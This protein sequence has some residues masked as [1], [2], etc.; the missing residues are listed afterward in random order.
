MKSL[1]SRIG[2][3]L[4]MTLRDIE[5][6]LYFESYVVIDPGMTTLEKGQMLTDE[7]Y[8]ESMEEFGDEF[9]AMMGAEA[10]QRLMQ[11]I[12]I[13]QEVDSLREEIPQQT[14]KPK[15]KNYPSV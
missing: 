8:Y 2:L 5:R 3:L 4:D 6:I 14:L 15:S 1:P 9:E 13:D 10:V 7:Q 11:D 12:D